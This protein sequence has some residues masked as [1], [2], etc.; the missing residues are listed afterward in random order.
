[1]RPRIEHV[2]VV[3]PARDEEQLVGRCLGSLQSARQAARAVRPDLTVD[4]VL[5]LD[6]CTDGTRSVALG[7]LDVRLVDLD[8]GRAGAARAAGVRDA[9]ARSTADPART[10][11]AGTDAD[12]VV[13]EGW[14]LEHLRLADAG[15]DV[16][17]GTVRPDPTDLSPAQLA[18]WRTTR[19]P[20]RPNGHV[21]GANLGVRADAYLRAG[22]FPDLPEHEDVD[23]VEAL[24]A[25]G[26]RVVATDDCDVLTSGRLVG[27]TPGGY[28]GYLRSRF[29]SAEDEAESA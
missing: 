16:V 13:P 28:A 4:L 15:A 18:A 26:A 21:H 12:S 25:L 29:G 6:R 7:H 10:W 8:E 3:V 22:G 5:V 9:L 17:V 11:V 24:T 27:R 23:L 1:M 2:V 20:G 19:V 14:I